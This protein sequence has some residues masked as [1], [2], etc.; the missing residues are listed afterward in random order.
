[1]HIHEY[2]YIYIYSKII[3]YF[4]NYIG[5]S[6]LVKAITN[7][8]KKTKIMCPLFEVDLSTNRKHTNIE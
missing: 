7:F 2:I 3:V 4:L 1:M 5:S 8:Y 6:C